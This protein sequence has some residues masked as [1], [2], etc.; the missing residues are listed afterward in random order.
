LRSTGVGSI[1]R[2]A[3]RWSK[4]APAERAGELF[5]A[6]R[7]NISLADMTLWQLNLTFGSAAATVAAEQR[8]FRFA[9]SRWKTATQESQMK[10][11]HLIS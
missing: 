2:T 3:V 9:G 8:Q 10:K 6:F 1:S 7:F 5:A 4:S 11:D